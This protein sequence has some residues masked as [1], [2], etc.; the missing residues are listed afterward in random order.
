MTASRARQRIEAILDAA[1]VRGLRT[2]DD[3]AQW[4][5]RLAAAPA[6]PSQA[7]GPGSGTTKALPADSLPS[8]VA[9]LSPPRTASP[10]SACGSSRLAAA[11]ASEAAEG[12]VGL[13]GYSKAR[14]RPSSYEDEEGR[15]AASRAAQPRSG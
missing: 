3:P 1:K 2:G 5:G 12:D 11:R 4:K 6:H 14:L 9:K 7:S 13:S 8:I 10:R 15:Q